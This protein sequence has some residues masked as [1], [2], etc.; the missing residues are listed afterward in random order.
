MS[1]AARGCP[2]SSRSCRS[3]SAVQLLLSCSFADLTLVD[4]HHITDFQGWVW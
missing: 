1:G 3:K 2:S 4:S